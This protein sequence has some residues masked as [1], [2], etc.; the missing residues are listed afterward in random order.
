[1]I[2]ELGSNPFV[3]SNSFAINEASST[4]ETTTAL[5][6]VEKDPSNPLL[7]AENFDFSQVSEAATKVIN[8]LSTNS[9][10]MIV[11]IFGLP[12]TTALLSIF[13]AGPLAIASI[14]WIIPISAVLFL[15]DLFNN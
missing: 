13:G 6:V 10:I 9:L 12:V 11:V 7:L 8:N 2:S 3:I 15:P 4:E 5:L 1:M 14:A